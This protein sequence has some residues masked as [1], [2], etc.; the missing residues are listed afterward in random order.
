MDCL[1]Y[2][3]DSGYILEKKKFIKKT[4]LASSVVNLKKRIAILGGS[5]TSEIKNILTLFLLDQGIEPEF[6]ESEF[7]QY[8]QDA[9]FNEELKEFCPDVIFIH[10]TSRNIT[11]YPTVLNSDE[12][13]TDM[14]ETQYSHFTV[15]W[16]KLLQEYHCP[17][18]QNN[19]ERLS[20]RL[21][22]NK[23]ISDIHGRNNFIARLNLKFY[24]YAQTHESFYIHDIDFLAA[25]Y[26]LDKWSDPFFWHMYKYALAVP[27]I[28]DLA[29]SL[30]NIIKSIYG[31]NK[32]S[33]VLDL[34][35]TL[36]GGV[37]GDDGVDGIV[38]GP[39]VS[40]GQVYS[41]FQD[42]IKSLKD[43]GIMLNVCS[44]NDHENA[45]LGLN[46]P[47]GSLKPD[48]FI[49]IK[50]NWENKDRN[51][52]EIANELNIGTDSLVFIDDNPAERAIVKAQVVGVEVPDIGSAEQY[53]H[54]IDHSGFFE[55]TNF[56]QDDIK[57]NDMY[58][59]NAERANLQQ[60]FGSYEDYLLSLEMVGTIRDFE[61][62]YMQ[63]I[64]QLTNKSNQFNLTTKR[65]SESELAAVTNDSNYIRLYG[66]LED[67]FGDNG[68]VS[69]IIGHKK[70]STLHID[71]WL[72]SCRVLKR[73]MEYAMLDTLID[74]CQIHEIIDII[75]YYYPTAK[76]NMVRNFYAT[77]G[78]DKISEDEQG[79]SVWHYYVGAHTTKNHEIKIIR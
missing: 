17:V 32:K 30:S 77:M 5:T 15:M 36:W 65:Y 58:K 42:Y 24:E 75:G 57:R 21:L 23:D 55:V 2:P 53:I 25:S 51:I 19:F 20:Y 41:E 49:V 72:M 12:Q 14:L 9:M 52:C 6:Y 74:E 43:L 40:M 78:F 67:K 39:E 35:N 33:L 44:K 10:T 46:H 71:L 79:N 59:A 54:R 70:V 29:F 37:V 26:G 4:L 56:S 68:V 11:S 64:A 38:I 27:A 34:D 31:K 62:I 47:D 3:F 8:W 18:I 69:I 45:I 60:R 22:G 1:T 61:P 28:P 73:N 66:K 16:D 76:N 50:A 13:I 48:D 63:R 7:G